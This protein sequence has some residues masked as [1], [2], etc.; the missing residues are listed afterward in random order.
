MMVIRTSP[1]RQMPLGEGGGGGL[2]GG[3]IGGECV[4]RG[5]EDG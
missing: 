5:K 1:K 2:C 4:W 3:E